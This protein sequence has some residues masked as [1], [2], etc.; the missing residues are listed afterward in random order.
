[1]EQNPKISKLW[2]W[3]LILFGIAMVLLTLLSGTLQNLMLPKAITG[4]ASADKLQTKIEGEGQLKALEQYDATN[5]NGLPILDIRVK[6]GDAVS[7]SDILVVYDTSELERGKMDIE[8][9]IKLKKLNGDKLKS[10][11]IAAKV[12]GDEQKIQEA[13]RGLESYEIDLGIDQRKLQALLQDIEKKR[14][15]KA[16]YDGIITEVKAS[17]N[18]APSSGQSILTLVKQAEGY[19]F[20]FSLTEEQAKWLEEKE[21]VEVE[22]VEG[23]KSARV[24]G[25]I[26]SIALG[27]ERTASSFGAAGVGKNVAGEKEKPEGS[28]TPD[29]SMFQVTITIT[30]GPKDMK[31]LPGMKAEIDI[32]RSP[33]GKGHVLPNEWIKQ[34]KDGKY[35][36]V[37]E[38]QLG[39]FGN[40]YTV[41]K[42]Y[43]KVIASSGEQSLVSGLTIKD[44]I[45]TESSEPLQAGDRVRL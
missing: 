2:R 4:K 41:K 9:G 39:A 43:V 24:K 35:V 37:V 36:L 11:Y 13:K 8:A 12:E 44:E 26:E 29:S 6:E 40:D 18:D 38:E 28:A 45:I 31:L 23:K 22:L 14:Y 3:L 27:A 10:D 5:S 20:T 16:P 33:K 7:K 1:M 25:N 34:D 17:K 32:L 30:E 19:Q 21:T 15:S 42:V